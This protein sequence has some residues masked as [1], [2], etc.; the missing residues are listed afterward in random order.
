VTTQESSWSA[1]AIQALIEL[2]KIFARDFELDTALK[3]ICDTALEL[4]N[5]EHASLRL[6]NSTRTELVAGA[7]SG[8]GESGRPVSFRPGEG[9]V[10][11]VADSGRVARIDDTAK[12]PR[13]KTV[14]NQGFSVRSLLI[15]PMA[16]PE[17]VIGVLGISASAPHAFEEQDEMLAVLLANC[18]MAPIEKARLKQLALTDEHTTAFNRRF[19]MPRLEAEMERAQEDGKAL[20]LTLIDVDHF[21][22]VNDTYGHVV[23]D[24]V[25][26]IVA[27][28]I[29]A[30]IREHDLLVRRG[31]DEFVVILPGADAE[32]AFYVGERIRYAVS[33]APIRSGEVTIHRT[34]SIGVATWDGSE[35]ALQFEHRAD[36][37]MYEAKSGGRDR[38]IAALIPPDE[39]ATGTS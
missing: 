4:T 11:W 5:G 22:T 1:D 16:S 33:N 13:F 17:G 25:L 24:D 7:R 29:K 38:V 14:A 34:V 39:E 31:G 21:K 23:G 37:A 19:M 6:L 12:D 30:A 2:T 28:R 9:V 20:S 15:V 27:K 35:T 26:R 8:S 18:A 36:L 32:S 3:A 10:G